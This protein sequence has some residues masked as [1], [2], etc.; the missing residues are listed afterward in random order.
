MRNVMRI[1][2]TTDEINMLA[3]SCCIRIIKQLF[4]DRN[5]PEGGSAVMLL[6]RGTRISI[7]TNPCDWF[8]HT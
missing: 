1:G 3:T 7:Y 4:R 2:C 8:K 5:T 6:S